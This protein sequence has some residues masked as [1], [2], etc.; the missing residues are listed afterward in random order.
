V[1]H[2]IGLPELLLIG[3]IGLLLL[4]GPVVVLVWLLRQRRASPPSLATR[5]AQCSACGTPLPAGVLV[6]AQCG[7]S[8]QAAP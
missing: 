5:L 8:R 6:C 3:V 1:G 2:A 7:T 4:V